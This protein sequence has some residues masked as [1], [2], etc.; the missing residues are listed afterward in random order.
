M[1]DKTLKKLLEDFST[2][3]RGGEEKDRQTVLIGADLRSANLT[4]ANL[5]GTEVWWCN[6]KGCAI[7]PA[8]LHTLLDSRTA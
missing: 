4:N 3:V 8:T 6:F 2:C 7:E 5:G 1:D